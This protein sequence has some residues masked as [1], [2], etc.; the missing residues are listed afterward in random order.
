MVGPIR[1]TTGPTNFTSTL[2]QLEEHNSLTSRRDKPIAKVES[3]IFSSIF[4]RWTKKKYTI[5][6]SILENM[7]DS[8]NSDLLIKDIMFE[9]ILCGFFLLTWGCFSFVALWTRKG[10]VLGWFGW[11]LK[12]KKRGACGAWVAWDEGEA[13][14]MKQIS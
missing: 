6:T 5:L 11:Y 14:E 7:H 10:S 2:V 12:K 1:P 4:V 3:S 8:L 13:E 9:V